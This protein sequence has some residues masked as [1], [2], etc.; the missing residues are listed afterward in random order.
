MF[1]QDSAS[2]QQFLR[3]KELFV[4]PDIFVEK[5]IVKAFVIVTR[6]AVKIAINVNVRF[7]SYYIYAIGWPMLW[8][9]TTIY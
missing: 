1:P 8:R 7:I 9:I 6:L 3:H 5:G 2:C 4:P